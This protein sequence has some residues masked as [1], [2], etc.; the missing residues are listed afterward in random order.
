MTS[1][2][3]RSLEAHELGVAARGYAQRHGKPGTVE[4]REAWL[5]F[6]ARVRT[7]EDLR[8]LREE[9]GTAGSEAA[10]VL[11]AA[12]TRAMAIDDASMADAQVLDSE[13]QLRI[14]AYSGFTRE[15]LQFFERVGETGSSCGAALST[16][17]ATWVPDVTKSP[18]FAGTPALDVMLA[19]GCR[20]VASLPLTS[21][22]GRVLGM[23]STHHARPREWNQQRRAALQDLAR[24]AGRAL[25]RVAAKGSART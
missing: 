17:R 1:P 10:K 6:R 20:A 5:E 8:R 16:G 4:Y 19:A 25:E 21:P 2:F 7:T 3:D 24:A 11:R 12:I 15:F 9:A 22:S 18:I 14:A 13:G 23:L